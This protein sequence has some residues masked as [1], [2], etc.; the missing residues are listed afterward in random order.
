MA[1]MGR[2]VQGW[3]WGQ[4]LRPS[5]ASKVFSGIEQH[6]D[7]TGWEVVVHRTHLLSIVMELAMISRAW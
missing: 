2:E 1:T 3:G 5:R 7:P 6:Q 4:S